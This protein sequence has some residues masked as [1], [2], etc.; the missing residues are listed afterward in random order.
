MA[1][2]V[3]HAGCGG[4]VHRG[5][6]GPEHCH[7]E[8]TVAGLWF[9][10]HGRTVWL[11]FACDQHAADLIAAR[12]LPAPRPGRPRPAPRQTTH[13]ARRPTMGRGGGRTPRAWC[14]G[15]SGSSSA[16]ERGPNAT[17]ISDPQPRPAV[18]RSTIG[19]AGVRTRRERSRCSPQRSPGLTT[20]AKTSIAVTYVWATRTLGWGSVMIGY[21]TGDAVGECGTSLGR[22]EHGGV[23]TAVGCAAYRAALPAA[24]ADIVVGVPAACA[25]C[26]AFLPRSGCVRAAWSA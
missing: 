8:P 18:V 20:P 10:V 25:A 6:Q 21:S 15:A 22:V 14:S 5:R 12:P 19:P 3:M 7:A 23:L 24:A 11:G 2:H 1:F 4:M 13:P 16:P 17:A 26:S 9:A